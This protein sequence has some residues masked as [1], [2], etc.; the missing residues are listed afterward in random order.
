MGIAAVEVDWGHYM[1]T[2][3]RDPV[4]CVVYLFSQKLLFLLHPLDT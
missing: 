3:S 1:T 2:V 4:T